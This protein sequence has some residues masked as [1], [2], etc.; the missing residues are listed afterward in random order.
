MR[1]IKR[2]RT[3]HWLS[4]LMTML[5]TLTGDEMAAV[6]LKPPVRV[7]YDGEFLRI[8]PDLPQEATSAPGDVQKEREALRAEQLA[9][10][11][12]L[13]APVLNAW[14]DLAND[15]KLAPEIDAVRKAVEAL[16]ARWDAIGGKEA[17]DAETK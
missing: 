11:R 4:E 17:D 7:S 3:C 15:E 8:V 10:V 12:D 2:G 6:P 16:S 1:T 13:I 14:D 5:D 9:S